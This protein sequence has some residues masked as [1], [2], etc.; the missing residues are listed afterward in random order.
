MKCENDKTER[1]VNKLKCGADERTKVKGRKRQGVREKVFEC[2]KRSKGRAE[3]IQR[4]YATSSKTRKL[5]ISTVRMARVSLQGKT[6][7]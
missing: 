7:S 4:P 6:T 3:G 1:S 5:T 2:A